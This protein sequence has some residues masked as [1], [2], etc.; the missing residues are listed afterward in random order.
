MFERLRQAKASVHRRGFA[1]LCLLALAVAVLTPAQGHAFECDEPVCLTCALGDA[2]DDLCVV[3]DTAIVPA[4][5]APPPAHPPVSGI[6]AVTTPAYRPRGPP[7][8]S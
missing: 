8:S 2:R 4:P 6:A 7:L 1:L 5:A 3:A